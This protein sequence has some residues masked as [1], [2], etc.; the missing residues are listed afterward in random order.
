LKRANNAILY[1]AVIFLVTGSVFAWVAKEA[2]ARAPW[3]LLGVN[4]I[5]SVVMI[6]LYLWGKRAPLAA[7]LV[8][9][10][11]YLVVIVLNGLAD[12]RTLA[13][14]MILKIVIV[15]ILV[16]GIKAALALRSEDG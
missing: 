1:L 14:G 7:L 9:T 12:P 5:L 8:A 11:T 3:T 15:M 10:A 2:G 16:N 13:Q 6:A 4:V